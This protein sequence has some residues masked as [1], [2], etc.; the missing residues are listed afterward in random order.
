MKELVYV[1]F[2]RA[3]ESP[4]SLLKRFAVHHGCVNQRQFNRLGV[5]DYSKG[6][7]LTTKGALPRWIASRAHQHAPKFL[8]GFYQP[9]VLIGKQ[10]PHQVDNLQVKPNLIR[11]K[12]NFFCS[13]CWAEEHEHFMKDLNFSVNCPYHNR[14]YLT[15]CPECGAR[16]QWIN[17]LTDKCNNCKAGLISP[18]CTPE[19]AAPE[20]YILSLFREHKQKQFDQLCQN[21]ATL[22]FNRE[23]PETFENRL[24]IET[25]ISLVN[26]DAP[27]IKH[28]LESMKK[29]FPHIPNEAICAKLT[30]FQSQ[31]VKKTCETFC[32][33]N[34]LTTSK[35]P[36]HS[37]EK[38]NSTNHLINPFILTRSQVRRGSHM[39]TK[40][41]SQ[42][43]SQT[44]PIWDKE[45]NATL[46]DSEIIIIFA[47][48]KEIKTSKPRSLLEAESIDLQT[49]AIN[50]GINLTCFRKLI[51]AGFLRTIK[52]KGCSHR[53]SIGQLQEFSNQYEALDSLAAR[54]ALSRPKIVDL[55]KEN[56][57]YPV[58]I[59]GVSRSILLQ[60]KDSDLL[61][62]IIQ[63]QIIPS[64]TNGTNQVAYDSINPLDLHLYSTM[65]DASIDYKIKNYVLPILINAGIL[66]PRKY[67]NHP[68]KAILLLK[69]ELD[70]YKKNHLTLAAAAEIIG[71]SKL[72]ARAILSDLGVYPVVGGPPGQSK[73][74]IFS[75]QDVENLV[76]EQISK[77]E[78]R[79]TIEQASRKLHLKTLTI[80]ELIKSGDLAAQ[81]DN[82]VSKIFADVEKVENFFKTH[83]DIV[84]AAKWCG[85]RW[86]SVKKFLSRLNIPALGDAQHKGRTIFYRIS[87]LEKAGILNHE[88]ATKYGS[89]A[90]DKPQKNQK[91]NL[92][93][94][95]TYID[96]LTQ[97]NEACRKFDVSLNWFISTFLKTNFLKTIKYGKNTYLTPESMEKLSEFLSEY[98]SL[99]TANKSIGRNRM[100]YRLL[101]FREIVPATQL[102]K[103]L[104]GKTFLLRSDF[105]K[106]LNQLGNS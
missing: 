16:L 25:A 71:V 83:V 85:V 96:R 78:N 11:W 92:Y 75:L 63:G 97:L 21:L 35:P 61:F 52:L 101:R 42:V 72:A 50:F 14:K 4:T 69:T 81:G 59:P 103:E 3:E 87:D 33:E 102:P 98:I 49:A 76:K 27:G 38:Y 24:A 93:E 105:N 82:H 5:P 60:K 62:S 10:I 32:I 79:L 13:E 7:C 23:H 48:I 51:A 66:H 47:K 106:L 19:D 34:N 68:R 36:P 65:T 15:H 74:W 54:A 22:N 77:T 99:P 31:T 80:Y 37:T 9:T 29:R 104:T 90:A 89:I 17:P 44:L 39:G 100:I 84:T 53:I 40:I 88:Q 8:S 45:K 64:K 18:T 1:P 58:G 70:D 46:S 43:I 56:N 95:L 55:M 28:Y 26:E 86:W 91:D 94:N 12:Y 6:T 57:I 2:P 30:L 41:F 73:I 20:R 67:V